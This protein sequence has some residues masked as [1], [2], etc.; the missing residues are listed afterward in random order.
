MYKI[1][2]AAAVMPT[3]WIMNENCFATCGLTSIASVMTG[4]AIDAPPS[5]VAPATMDPKII[6]TLM[7]HGLT[8]LCIV[9]MDL[10]FGRTLRN[11]C[12][13]AMRSVNL[14]QLFQRIIAVHQTICTKRNGTAMANCLRHFSVHDSVPSSIFACNSFS[15]R[16]PSQKYLLQKARQLSFGVRFRTGST[17]CVSLG[18]ACL[19]LR[20]AILLLRLLGRV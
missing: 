5:E 1:T 7:Y 17:S 4:K 6:V 8:L 19:G 3:L 18:S 9:R 14:C 10:P 15:T 2:N 12:C 16:C 13:C 20:A 11:L